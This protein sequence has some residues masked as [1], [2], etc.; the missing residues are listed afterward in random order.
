MPECD[1]RYIPQN[2][3]EFQPKHEQIFM[4]GASGQV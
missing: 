1:E 3:V 4:S 2:A